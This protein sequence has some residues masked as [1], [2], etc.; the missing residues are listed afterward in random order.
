MSEPDLIQTYNVKGEN[1]K[2]H[3]DII[4]IVYIS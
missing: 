2:L 1:S 4:N 3:N